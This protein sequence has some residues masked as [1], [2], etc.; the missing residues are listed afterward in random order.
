MNQVVRGLRSKLPRLRQVSRA[1]QSVVDN[2]WP[3]LETLVNV[4]VDSHGTWATKFWKRVRT[5]CRKCSQAYRKRKMVLQGTRDA[6]EG[7]QGESEGPDGEE[8]DVVSRMQR[9]APPWRR[10]RNPRDKWLRHRD[11]SPRRRPP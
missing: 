2:V 10:E 8:M 11:E 1:L 3:E 6:I 4:H 7:A 9:T 5:A